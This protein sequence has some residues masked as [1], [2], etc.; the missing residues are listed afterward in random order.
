MPQRY[1]DKIIEQAD[2]ALEALGNE[3]APKAPPT[4]SAV[5][6]IEFGALDVPSSRIPVLGVGTILP[7]NEPA[8]PTVTLYY[9]GERAAEGV[10]MV[11]NGMIA[12]KITRKYDGSD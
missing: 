5:L 7:L 12:V 2:R 1:T 10:L 6:E 9:G 3:F 11:Q 4:E 8:E